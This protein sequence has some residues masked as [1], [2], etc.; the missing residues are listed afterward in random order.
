MPVRRPF[1]DSGC[2]EAAQGKDMW[3]GLISAVGGL[4]LIAAAVM[5]YGLMTWRASLPLLEGTA[6]MPGL[7]AS[8]TVESDEYGVP[9]IRAGSQLDA[10]RALGYLTARDR[11]FQMDMLRRRSAG[12]LAEVLGQAALD[13]DRAQRWI[14]L[15]RAAHEIAFSLPSDQRDVLQAYADGV[16]G[17]V[18]RVGTLPFEFLLLGYR[19]EPWGVEDSILVVLAMFQTLT[20]SEEDE[21]M[22]STM[23]AT[24]P[25]DVVAFLTPEVDR[26]TRAVWGERADSRTTPVPADALVQLRH[27]S[28]A[29][30]ERQETMVRFTDAAVG[31]NAWAVGGR[32]TA[33]GRA[34]LANDMHL[35]LAVP[36][37]WYRVEL[38]YDDTVLSGVIMPGV[39]V[40]VAGTNGHVAW[41]VTNLDAD[42]LDLV[43]VDLRPDAPDEYRVGDQWVAME[44]AD[45]TI[46]VRGGA[47]VAVQVRRTVWGP[48]APKP[49]GGRLVAIHWTALDPSA[50][51]LGLLDMDGAKTLEQAIRTL[52]RA[53]APASNVMLADAHGRIAWTCMGRIPVRR[54][55]DGSSTVSWADGRNGWARYIA[56][57]E[58]PRLVDPP[59]GFLV[60]ANHRATG[61][62]YP[63]LIGR[64]FANGYRAYRITERLQRMSRI[65]EADMLRLQLD[66]TTDLYELYRRLALELLTERVLERRPFLAEVRAAIEAWNGQADVNSIGLGLLVRFRKTLAYSVL[67]PYLQRC[68]EQ[69]ASFSYGGDVDTPLERLLL[70]RDPRLLPEP[71][72]YPGWDAFLVAKLEDTARRLEDRHGT[73]SIRWLTWGRMN[74]AQISH[75]LATALPG[76]GWIVNMPADELPG[77][78]FCVRLTTGTL[79]ASERLVISPGHAADAILHM[80]GGQSGHPL[81]P[82]YRDQHEHWV[83]GSP[84]SFVPGPRVHTLTLH[85]VAGTMPAMSRGDPRSA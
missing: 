69:D 43:H 11:L 40:I 57:D 37:V 54:G 74:R 8:V 31:S 75:P 45:E 29:A 59:S 2:S 70:E 22:R 81:S 39:P 10:M 32:K 48:I 64:T 9:S 84:L 46:K 18:E 21:R 71:K 16:N 38:R 27:A 23:V 15:K 12:R 55:Y 4:G 82:H 68:R 67:G 41:G 19:P 73:G 20:W 26:Y 24:L 47:D 61:K 62:E 30:P 65:T 36:N 72:A 17:F 3:K 83:S 1:A 5:G 66:T 6:D 49:L 28:E 76:L 33:D 51:D 44:R 53:G 34:I 56:P 63:F 50:V 35:D 60:S 42:V 79:S 80:P 7:V 25:P 14:G 77:C 85:P 78:G 58:L 52:N 13:G